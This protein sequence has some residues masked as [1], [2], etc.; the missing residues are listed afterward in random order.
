MRPGGGETMSD[1]KLN[2]K[3]IIEIAIQIEKSG[4]AFYKR[5]K[6]LADSDET[7]E[8]FDYLEAAEYQHIADFTDV[9]KSALAKHK[10]MEY[11]TTEEELLYL[12][13]FASR[14]IFSSPED[15]INKAEGFTDQLDAIDM[16]IDFELN[17]VG[18]YRE[19]A[20]LIEDPADKASV[21]ELQKQE[22]A[23]AAN[24]YRIRNKLTA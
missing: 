22:K 14:Q 23:H 1:N 4:A 24:L 5:L 2:L 9:L 19:M 6:E 20:D 7:R 17:S 18:F 8:L 13:A 16:A 15:A 3:E 10:N 21:E 12:R 11:S